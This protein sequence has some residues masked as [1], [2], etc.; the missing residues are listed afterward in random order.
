MKQLSLKHR[1]CVITSIHSP[2][3][4][5]FHMFDNIYVLSKSGHNLYEGSPQQ[6]TQYL[7]Q[8]NIEFTEDDIPIELVLK[9]ASNVKNNETLDKLILNKKSLF[10]DKDLS[11]MNL[12]LSK[13]GINSK[14]KPFKFIDIFT[15]LM[16]FI[17]IHLISNWKT[18]FKQLLLFL[19]SGIFVGFIFN[20][21]FRVIDGC[22]DWISNQTCIEREDEKNILIQSATYIHFL[23]VISLIIHLSVMTNSFI[24]DF[25]AFSTEYRNSMYYI[26]IKLLNNY[27]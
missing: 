5:L 21:D 23:S 4:R 2:N 15:L 19:M 14:S 8:C 17:S 16:R 18:L 11:E 20:E 12:S 3:N 26:C 22:I 24:T 1:I 27:K 25:K 13:N 6:L 9:F 10:N 7:I